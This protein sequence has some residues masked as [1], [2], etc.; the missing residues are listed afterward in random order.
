[1]RLHREHQAR[2]FVFSFGS[3]LLK[4]WV[5]ALVF[6][7]R[8]TWTWKLWLGFFCFVLG[9]FKK[10]GKNRNPGAGPELVFHLVFANW[11]PEPTARSSLNKY[12]LHALKKYTENRSDRTYN[13]TSTQSKVSSIFEETSWILFR[14][15]L[16]QNESMLVYYN[17]FRNGQKRS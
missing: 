17:R 8:C 2:W 6:Y 12:T 9:F 10:G 3:S 14:M 7:V 15:T 4:L 13:A 16:L 5:W 11:T 1:M